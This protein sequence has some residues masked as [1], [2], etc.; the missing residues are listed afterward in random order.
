MLLEG[1]EKYGAILMDCQM[2][3][4]D[5]YD[6]TH[7][8]RTEEQYSHYRNT[9]I[10]ALTAHAM[11]GDAEKCLSYGMNSFITKPVKS[12]VLQNELERWLF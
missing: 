10:I 2:P 4:L 1:T 8:I 9:P 7:I 6:T 11:D 12:L 5:G 3:V